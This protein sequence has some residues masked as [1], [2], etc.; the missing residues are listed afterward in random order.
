MSA[1][2]VAFVSPE[3][4]AADRTAVLP[5]SI[6]VGKHNPRSF[7]SPDGVMYELVWVTPAIAERWLYRNNSNRPMRSDVVDKLSRDMIAGRFE[8][9]GDAVRVSRSGDLMDAQ[10]RLAARQASG[11][12]GWMLVVSNLPDEARDTVDDGAKRTM[13]DRFAFHGETDPKTLAAV[14]RRALLWGRGTKHPTAKYQP[15]ALESFEFLAEHPELRQASQAAMHH[16]KAKLLAPSTIGLCWWLFAALD[17]TQC[18]EFFDRLGDG[19]MLHKGNPILTLRNRLLDLNSQPGRVLEAHAT[20][21][22]IKAWNAVR[23]GR[24]MTINRFAENEKFPTPK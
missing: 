13:G 1:T 20:A 23:E 4:P 2:A 8:E 3:D 11:T 7:A 12:S 22:T 17:E 14:V 5:T 10:H 15:S 24:D 19:A 16:R 18:S 6:V 9:N 21:M